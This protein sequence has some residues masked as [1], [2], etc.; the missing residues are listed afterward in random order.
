MHLRTEYSLKAIS[1]VQLTCVTGFYLNLT[2]DCHRSMHM[3][4]SFAKS[5]QVLTLV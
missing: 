5:C 1:V 3:F 2:L 4:K